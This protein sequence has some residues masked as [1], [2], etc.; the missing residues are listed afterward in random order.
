MI[1]II[2]YF[3]NKFRFDKCKIFDMIV[4]CKLCKTYNQNT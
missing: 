1:L 2:V 3:Y 4:N